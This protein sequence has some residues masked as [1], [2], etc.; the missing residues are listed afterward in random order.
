MGNGYN[1]YYS[2]WCH[3]NQH[4]LYDMITDSQQMTNLYKPYTYQPNE[5]TTTK[6]PVNRLESRLDALM[7]VLKSCKAGTCT[8]PW[9]ALHPDGSVTNLNDAMAT[10]YDKFYEEEQNR[11]SFSWCDPGYIIA[12]E[13]P[14]AYKT[15][16]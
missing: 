15:Y 14:Q 3:D 13:G 4:E 10:K 7:L 5:P 8:Q 6:Y 11:V 12:A 9:L 1:F 2:V 16:M